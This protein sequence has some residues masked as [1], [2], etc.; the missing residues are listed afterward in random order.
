MTYRQKLD[1][2]S[3]NEPASKPVAVG[4]EGTILHPSTLFINVVEPSASIESARCDLSTRLGLDNSDIAALVRF[5]ETL[6]RWD[7]EAMRPM[8][9]S[10][11]K[12]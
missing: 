10:E 5:F 8:R 1:L 9:T 12:P 4:A 6:D 2:H 11:V 7:R 3:A